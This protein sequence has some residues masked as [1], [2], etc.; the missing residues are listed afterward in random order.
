VKSLA[1][2]EVH[3]TD[4]YLLHIVELMRYRSKS[5]TYSAVNIIMGYMLNLTIILGSVLWIHIWALT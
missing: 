3:A 2:G 4:E 5:T 1:G